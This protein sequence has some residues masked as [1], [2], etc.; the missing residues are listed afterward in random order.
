MKEG[1][2]SN[3]YVQDRGKSVDRHRCPMREH[4]PG[5]EV[6]GMDPRGGPLAAE[7]GICLQT[8]QMLSLCSATNV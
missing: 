2:K 1:E 3:G 5:S 6:G 4:T 7:E 8:Q